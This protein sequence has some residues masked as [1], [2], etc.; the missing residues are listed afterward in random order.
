[1]IKNINHPNLTTPFNATKAWELFNIENEDS[2][3]L[4]PLSGSSP[5]S[6]TYVSLDYIDYNLGPSPEWNRLCN[7]ALEQQVQDQIMFE[8]GV[9][10]SAA[11]FDPNV[12]SQNNNGTY[13]NL[14]YNQ[15]SRAFYNTYHNPI[16]IFGMENIDFPLSHTNRYLADTF[17]MFTIPQKMFGDKL[18]EGTIHF[19]DTAFD[20]NVD[21]YDDSVGNL[22]AYGNLFSKTQEV[23]TLENLV[24]NGSATASYVCPFPS[25]VPPVGTPTIMVLQM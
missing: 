9:S 16:Q 14:L 10:G 17:R 24:V 19:Y 25:G 3:L 15:I 4:E 7:I 23:R 6:D 18:V 21:I 8:E 12:S 1:M 22:V 13:K 11:T 2:I 20:D 5:I